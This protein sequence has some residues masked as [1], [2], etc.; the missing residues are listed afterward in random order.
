MSTTDTEERRAPV[1]RATERRR[2]YI[3]M[4]L[5]AA[6]AVVILIPMVRT[7]SIEALPLVAGMVLL[8]PG[9]VMIVPGVFVPFYQP[10]ITA[11]ANFIH[12]RKQE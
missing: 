3:G 7:S 8:V 1:D 5:A 6:G 2:T 4:A 10:L 12:S 9:C 11:A